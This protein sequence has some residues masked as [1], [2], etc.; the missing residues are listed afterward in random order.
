MT[1]Q[2]R[3]EALNMTRRLLI[4]AMLFCPC[5]NA[6][7]FNEQSLK[8]LFTSPPERQTINAARRGGQ[9][10]G[11]DF[12]P[13]PA[14]VHV[15]GIMKRSN[16]K[17]VVWINNKNTMNSSMV[18]G[19]KVYSNAMNKNNKIPVRVDGR[20]VYV[21]PGETWSEETGVVEDNY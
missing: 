9:S 13:G 19:V 3:V 10:S 12:V 15:K 6:A 11:S 14:G 18:D 1:E 21:K 20:M 7:G 4:F 5:A 16:G 8:T 2:Q 17:S